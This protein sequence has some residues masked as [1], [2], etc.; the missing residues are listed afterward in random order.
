MSDELDYFDPSL[1]SPYMDGPYNLIHHSFLP[2]PLESQL[3][4]RSVTVT[5]SK[6][7][8]T[9]CLELDNVIYGILLVGIVSR[10]WWNIEFFE[11][12]E[13]HWE[14]IEKRLIKQLVAEQ[15]KYGVKFLTSAPRRKR[16]MEK[17]NG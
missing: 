12:V 5:Q 15:E 14:I 17:T 7:Q 16:W 9:F 3:Q 8:I 2:M 6:D 10:R 13:E 4:A 1:W 11:T